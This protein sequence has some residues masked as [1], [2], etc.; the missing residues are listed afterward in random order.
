VDTQH[1]DRTLQLGLDS[2]SCVEL[3]RTQRLGRVILTYRALPMAVPV[4]YAVEQE[5][6]VLRAPPAGPLALGASGSVVALE[7]DALDANTGFG[8]SVMVTGMAT[9]VTDPAEVDALQRIIPTTW[10]DTSASTTYLRIPF[11]LVSGRRLGTGP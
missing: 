4:S 5:S 1:A 2:H 7:A 8:W 9:E 10:A 6:V 11:A 3:L